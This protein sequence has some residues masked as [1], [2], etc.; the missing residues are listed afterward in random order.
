MTPA[1]VKAQRLLAHR[2][3]EFL[4][5]NPRN[6]KR[7]AERLRKLR[8]ARLIVERLTQRETS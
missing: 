3:L 4:R 2:E 6:R 5:C 7:Y 1:L 8:E